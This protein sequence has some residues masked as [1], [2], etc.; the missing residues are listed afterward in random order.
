MSRR[1]GE[2][3]LGSFVLAPETSKRTVWIKIGGPTKPNKWIYFATWFAGNSYFSAQQIVWAR[4]PR[5]QGRMLYVYW[6]AGKGGRLMRLIVEFTT[7]PVICGPS[8]F[9][10]GH[11]GP[12]CFQQVSPFGANFQVAKV[13]CGQHLEEWLVVCLTHGQLAWKMIS[14][15]FLVHTLAQGTQLLTQNTSAGI[16]QW[17]AGKSST[18][19]CFYHMNLHF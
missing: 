14:D 17:L 3:K 2:V 6:G 19:R 16:K 13:W 15:P 7:W 1:P 18:Y 5:I 11:H 12:S 9:L 4:L 8:Y 10:S